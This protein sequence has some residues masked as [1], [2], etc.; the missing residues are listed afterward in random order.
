MWLETHPRHPGHAAGPAGRRETPSARA[1]APVRRT[2]PHR[3]DPRS[4]PAADRPQ[5]PARPPG[6]ITYAAALCRVIPES[7]SGF[8]QWGLAS[9]ERYRPE[10]D[11]QH[12]PSLQGRRKRTY[13]FSERLGRRM[14]LRARLAQMANLAAGIRKRVSCFP[15][16]S[17]RDDSTFWTS[18]AAWAEAADS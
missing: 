18:Q 15:S 9:R 12:A 16:F 6:G 17:A 1:G 7:C 3:A 5:T 8:P 14:A 11:S 10:Q 13:G 4:V 2:L